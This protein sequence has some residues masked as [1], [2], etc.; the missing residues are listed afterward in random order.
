MV[1]P[2]RPATGPF[3]RQNAPFTIAAALAV[4][5][6]T[7]FVLTQDVFG[8]SSAAPAVQTAPVVST[9]ASD[10]VADTAEASVDSAP[11]TQTAPASAA[12]PLQ[13]LGTE[14]LLEGLAQPVFATTAP[15][16]DRIYVVERGGKILIYDPA[17]GALNPDPFLDVTHKSKANIGIEVGLLGLAFHPDYAENG[18]LF[19]YYTDTNSDTAVAEYARQDADQVDPTSGE[20][21]IEVAREGIRHNAG[22]LLFGPDGYLYV[23]IGDGGMFE[24]FGQNPNVFLGTILRLDMDTGDPYSAPDDNPFFSGGGA[25][26][27]WAYGLRNPWRFS[28]DRASNTMFIGDVGQADAEEINAVALEPAGYN[29]GWPV[30]EGNN[31]WLPR[32]GCDQTGIQLPTTVYSHTEGCSV[33]GGYVY[34]GSQIPEYYGH[35]FYADWCLGWVRS[36][37]Y[38]G[39]AVLNPQDWSA[40]LANPGQITSFGLDGDGEML[41]TTFEGTLGRIVAVR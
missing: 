25:P 31:C 17:T 36:F 22:M 37:E 11:T 41:Y 34:R 1:D 21:F 10:P 2:F 12:S 3:A 5:A 40:D 20:V 39:G 19:I 33:T 23:A 8:E 26:E 38:A 24:E 9:L 16:D 15:G 27:V 7:W 29:F 28:I 13:S 4:T 30:M 14:V 6:L 35:Y 18:R 32:E